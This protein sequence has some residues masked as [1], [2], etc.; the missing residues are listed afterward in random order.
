[1]AIRNLEVVI[2]V[3]DKASKDLDRISKKVRE[4]G[5]SAK[6]AGVDFTGFNR[7][8]FATTAFVG[9]FVK[10]FSGLN[11]SFEEGAGLDRLSNQ[12]ER[13]LGPKSH[14]SSMLINFTD[15]FVDEFEA[16]RQ[17][18]AL[19]SMGIVRGVDQVAEIFARASVAAKQA[20][21]ESGEGIK[22]YADF[23][24]DGNVSHLQFLNL[25]AQSNPALQAQM[26]ILGK[27]G[28]V[29]SNVIST[30]ARLALGQR[31]LFLATKDQMKGGR[32]LTDTL[33]FLNQQWQFMR[34]ELG[35]LFLTAMQPILEGLA[36]FINRMRMVIDN[37][38][39][40]EKHIVFLTKVT[41]I[42]TGAILGF[43]GALGTLRLAAIALSSL[44]FGLPRL[45]FL[46]LSLGTAFLGIT[47]QA[48]G[49]I[50]KLRVFGAFVKGV[51]QL[52]TN[53]NTKTGIAMID[54]DIKKLLEE[55]GI[56][57]FA[58]N[59][60]RGISVVKRVVLDMVDAFNWMKDRLDDIFG[61]IFRKFINLVGSF[62]QPWENFWVT[63]TATSM[64]KFVR[65]FTVIGGTIGSI[66]AGMVGRAL[67]GKAGNML[68]KVPGL[69]FLGGSGRGPRGTRSDP[70]Y[71]RAADS[72][73]GGIVDMT[74]NGGLYLLDLLKGPMGKLGALFTQLGT[75]VNY[76]W[77]Y[78]FEGLKYALSETLM[79][80][81]RAAG[82][83]FM[84]VILPVAIFGSALY[85]AVQ[86]FWETMG[87]WGKFFQ[88]IFD[89]GKAVGNVVL[90]FVESIP[91]LK[92]LKD[93]L[94][95]VGSSLFKVGKFIL[96]DA[97]MQL[98]KM[99]AAGWKQI[100]GWLGV[101]A[102]KLGESMTK[103]AKTISPESFSGGG[104]MPEMP[105]E[106]TAAM[107]GEAP[108]GPGQKTNIS[109][110]Q[111][112][113]SPEETLD[114]LGQQLKG[115]SDGQ[116]KSAQQAIEDAMKSDSAGGAAIT[117]EEMQDIMKSMANKQVDLLGQIADNTKPIRSSSVGS[118]R[119]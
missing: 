2:T 88:G 85:G 36:L 6:K 92:Y 11:K 76:T 108:S 53:L 13:V 24:K 47:K 87:E 50:G 114:A 67:I 119:E 19:K 118:R 115:L 41:I 68:S 30:Q 99:I 90:K 97:P 94:V 43:A 16:M 35:R 110:P 49:V 109:V 116:R 20:G 42:A 117:A 54:E 75:V 106:G 84:D 111:D 71:T 23:L 27:V 103:W 100:F 4:T 59:V 104:V 77:A 17:G 14:L 74:K 83:A 107:N 40:N 63:D 32:D 48:D 37:V 86:G 51:Y 39:A 29:M 18:I 28:G 56:F 55:N 96:I 91:M 62:K 105:L 112:N 58:Q 38:R 33:R 7:T 12:F 10:L 1:M 93:I 82:S 57:T 66:F 98:M 80:I 34:G 5:D 26:A 45:I 31:L 44:G 102:G 70:M 81:L 21:K 64:Q 3:T 95:Y 113:K 22:S 79:P 15:S 69:G 65:N 52:V 25:I 9:T 89:L 101:G 60:A 78:G 46:V 8:L 73:S 72:V 61:G